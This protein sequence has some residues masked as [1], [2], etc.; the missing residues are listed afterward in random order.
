[1]PIHAAEST[2]QRDAADMTTDYYPLLRKAIAGLDQPD[3]PARYDLYE[4]ARQALVRQLR[5]AD[6]DDAEIDEQ[7]AAL[8]RAVARIERELAGEQTDRSAPAHAPAERHQRTPERSLQ[9]PH[10]PAAQPPRRRI[11]TAIGAALAVIVLVGISAL[12][13]GL[14]DRAPPAVAS[15]GDTVRPAVAPTAAS[16]G[17]DTG[18]AQASYVLRRQR[19]YY[20]TTHPAGTVILSLNQ[21]FLY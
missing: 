2:N 16:A 1:M 14:R 11:G 17:P 8:R 18:A 12:Y 10:A 13:V 19:V 5:T 3:E 6:R 15:R 7:I 4:R 21:R 20:R 9:Q